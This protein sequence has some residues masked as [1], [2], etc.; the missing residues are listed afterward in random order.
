MTKA[1]LKRILKQTG[2]LTDAQRGAL[3]CSLLG[4]PKIVEVCMGQV[5][6]ARCDA[7]LGDT[8]VGC[9]QL[10]GKVLRGHQQGNCSNCH[11]A[12]DPL[13]WKHRLYVRDPFVDDFGKE[14]KAP[15]LLEL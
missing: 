9:Y 15:F 4:H 1:N 6:C 11:A 12:F 5:T 14:P 10:T 3:I 13:D 8:L 2:K 7:I